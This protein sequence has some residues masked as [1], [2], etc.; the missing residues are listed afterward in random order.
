MVIII[1][2]VDTLLVL[3]MMRVVMASCQFRECQEDGRCRTGIDLDK[4]LAIHRRVAVDNRICVGSF[5]LLIDQ[6]GSRLLLLLEIPI[7]EGVGMGLE[8]DSK[9]DFAVLGCF[10]LSLL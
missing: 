3:L 9:N 1:T 7:W 10:G 5:L 8:K 6:G 4:R 2:D